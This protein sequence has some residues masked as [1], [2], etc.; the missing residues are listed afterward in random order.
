MP[1]FS[2]ADFNKE[3]SQRLSVII[4][5]RLGLKPLH[6]FRALSDGQQKK[7]NRLMNEYIQTLGEDWFDTIIKDFNQIVNE[8]ILTDTFDASTI[9]IPS[10]SVSERELLLSEEQKEFF[11]DKPE[12]FSKIKVK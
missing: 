1:K 10:H 2:T 7:F 9:H 3:N 6:S 12:E 4:M 5:P 11:A 8:E